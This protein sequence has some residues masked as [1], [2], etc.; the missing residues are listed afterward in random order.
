MSD[1][2]FFSIPDFWDLH[3]FNQI[4]IDFI[5]NNLEKCNS[6]IN[7]T[8]IFGSFPSIWA[9]G[10]V[11]DGV[12][13]EKDIRN[14]LKFYNSNNISIR[15]TFTNTYLNDKQLL[16]DYIS[17][18][19]CHYCNENN[20]FYHVQNA[21]IINN[22][23][24]AEYIQKKYPLLPIIYSTTKEC[25]TIQDIN[26]YSQ[27]NLLIPSYTINHDFSILSQIKHPEN[28]ELLCIEQGCI[29]NCPKRDIH[30][31]LISKINLKKDVDLTKSQFQCP[32][33]SELDVWYNNYNNPKIFI[34]LNEIQEKYL[35]L[36]FNKF[37]ISGRGKMIN[38][39]INNLESYIHYFIKPE[40]QNEVRNY[41]L[42]HTLKGYYFK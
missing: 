25:K 42:I 12:V 22:L 11:V 23:Y 10:R 37:K 39:V 28:I 34:S 20:E 15:N 24:L 35:P 27:Q 3:K 16:D 18:M 41:L 36:G 17:N 30:Q 21:C 6:N 2:I 4:F 32:K 8:S 9:G 40:Y 29:P 26:F 33:S 1:L 13:T 19:I 5:Q 38:N 31:D 14:T 7:I